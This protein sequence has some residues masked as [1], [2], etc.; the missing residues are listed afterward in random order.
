[1]ASHTRLP[2]RRET[3]SNK[4]APARSSPAARRLINAVVKEKGSE[5]KAAR[6]LRL[7]NSAQLSKMR[8]GL[9]KDT[10]AMRAALTRANAR[11]R[12]AWALAPAP[13]PVADL[14]TARAQLTIVMQSLETLAELLKG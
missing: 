3:R 6:A 7:P 12:R 2:L 9:L 10:P 14:E 4:K 1:M 11:A 5:V 13:A 8:R